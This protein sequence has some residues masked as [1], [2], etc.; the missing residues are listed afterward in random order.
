MAAWWFY[1]V[2]LVAVYTG[3]LIAFISV[4]RPKLPFTT[5]EEM[6]EQDEYTFGTLGGTIMETKLKVHGY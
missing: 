5:P 2:I 1:C 3:N 6:V 4:N